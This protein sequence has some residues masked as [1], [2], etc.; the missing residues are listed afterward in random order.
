MYCIT[1]KIDYVIMLDGMFMTYLTPDHAIINNQDEHSFLCWARIISLRL[2]PMSSSEKENT[3]DFDNLFFE[4]YVW[5]G[6]YI[7]DVESQPYVCLY[8]FSVHSF[9]VHHLSAYCTQSTYRDFEVFAFC[10]PFL[11]REAIFFS[12]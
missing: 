6:N 3:V 9:R 2:R 12:F 11:M 7:T 5:D 1:R 8:P 10:S 4:L